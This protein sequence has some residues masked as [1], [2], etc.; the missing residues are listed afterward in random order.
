M[1]LEVKRPKRLVL[2]NSAM[3]VAT[4]V[5]VTLAVEGIYG[6]SS[7]AS[8]EGATTATVTRGTV[9][10]TASTSGNISPATTTSINFVTS[11]T[12]TAVDDRGVGDANLRRDLTAAMIVA[13]GLIR[14]QG[15]DHPQLRA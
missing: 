13:G 11:G 4:A 5:L 15:A 6:G 14:P 1:G 2:F 10:A 9:L 7:S 12:L 3:A 8:G